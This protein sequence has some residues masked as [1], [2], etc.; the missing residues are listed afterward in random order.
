MWG[1]V[2]DRGPAQRDLVIE[3][4]GPEHIITRQPVVADDAPALPHAN[5][6]TGGD[7]NGVFEARHA[8]AEKTVI[9]MDLAPPFDLGSSQLLRIGGVDIWN[10]RHVSTPRS[11][12]GRDELEVGRR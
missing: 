9:L 3:A 12:P 7:Q 5:R 4:P 6:G 11:R 10:A 8:V 2:L 1:V